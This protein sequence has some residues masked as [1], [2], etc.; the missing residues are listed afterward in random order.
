[1]RELIFNSCLKWSVS[2]LAFF[3]IGS[4]IEEINY[5]EI[6]PRARVIIESGIR[7]GIKFRQFNLKRI[8]TEIFLAQQNGKLLVFKHLPLQGSYRYSSQINL[9][10][11]WRA[12][13]LMLNNSLPISFAHKSKAYKAS[14]VIPRLTF[15]VFIK[16]NRGSLSKKT[17]KVNNQKE[18]LRAVSKF[19]FSQ[20]ILIEQFYQGKDYRVTLVDGKVAAACLREPANVIGDGRTTLGR[21][22]DNKNE[23]RKNNRSS[24]LKPL[25]KPKNL[26]LDKIIDDRE[27]V[28]LCSKV[29]LA[30]GADII[31]VTNKVSSE[32][33]EMFEKIGD[34]FDAKIIGI[35]YLSPN[36][37][38]P[39]YQN[40]G[41]IIELNSLPYINMH[42]EPYRGESIDVAGKLWDQII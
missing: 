7:K 28:Y 15:P 35:D 14:K 36:I 30:S 5:E 17:Y 2:L 31:D 6:D 40:D 37:S 19:K 21:L 26:N 41:R 4:F 38:I 32:N 3:N 11:K 13:Q 20:D 12:K 9:D 29:N 42:H 39:H 18:Y 16:P 8:K 22:I 25:P 23:D 34:I 33:I 24:T 10:D 1:M 27:K